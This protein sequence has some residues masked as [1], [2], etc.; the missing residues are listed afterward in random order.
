MTFIYLIAASLSPFSMA[1]TEYHWVSYEE[2]KF[3]Q[4]MV[5]ETGKSK[6]M[7]PTSGGSHHKAEGKRTSFRRAHIYN[8]TTPIT[9]PLLRS[10]STRGK[11]PLPNH[12][13]KLPLLNTV[14][15][16][17]KFWRGN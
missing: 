13:L 17:T 3:T 8:E 4:F 2:R 7:L 1:V 16:V 9:N 15:M 6:S 11:P 12:S 14:T 5:L 10:S